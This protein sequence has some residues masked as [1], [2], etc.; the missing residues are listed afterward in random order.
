[1]P[2]LIVEEIYS[3]RKIVV[4]LVFS[5]NPLLDPPRKHNNRSLQN[6][7]WV[8]EIPYIFTFFQTTFAP[9]FQ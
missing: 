8:L 2:C 4:I 7:L 3:S 5:A 6:P 1:M 9:S